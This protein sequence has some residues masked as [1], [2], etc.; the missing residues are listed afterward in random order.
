MENFVIATNGDGRVEAFYIGENGTV[1]HTWQVDP[2]NKTVWS[3]PTALFGTSGNS[4]GPLENVVR[5]EADSGMRG[6][7]Q[8]VAYTREGKYYTCYQTPGAWA[9]WLEIEQQ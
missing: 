3:A 9:G 1:M 4:N 5:V 7:I 2:G 8:V 6:Q